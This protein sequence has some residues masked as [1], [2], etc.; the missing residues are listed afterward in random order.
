MTRL[1]AY[2]L[3]LQAAVRDGDRELARVLTRAVAQETRQKV[4]TPVDVSLG[5]FKR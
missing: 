2:R 3:A 5:H 4:S 1:E